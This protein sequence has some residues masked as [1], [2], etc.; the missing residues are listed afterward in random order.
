V[1]RGVLLYG[2]SGAG[3]SSLINAGL[4]P[5]AI[6]RGFTPERLRVQ[7]RQGAEIVVERIAVD[8]A[9]ARYL[10]S[11]LVPEDD[12][13]PRFVLSATAFR[14]RVLEAAKGSS[15]PLL[16]FD[17]FEELVTLFEETRGGETLREGRELQAVVV[18]VLIELL[19]LEELRVKLVLSFREDYLAKVK[20]LLWKRPELVDQ[21]VYLTPP[22]TDA[23]YKIIRGPFESFP[24]R[25]PRE[26]TR[27]LAQRI[28]EAFESRSGPG[29]IHLSE[30]QVVCNRLSETDEPE[31]LF[32]ERGLEGIV[33]DSVLEAIN[34]FPDDLRYSALTVLTQ[35]V[36]GSGVRTVISADDLVERV[37]DD[38][39]IEESQ[40]REALRR[41]EQETRLVR[42]E[43]RRDIDVYEIISE[44]LV[45]WIS[46]LREQRL[47]WLLESEVAQRGRWKED[48]QRAH[49]LTESG[50]EKDLLDAVRITTSLLIQSRYADLDTYT[51]ASGL[52]GWLHDAERPTAVRKAAGHGMAAAATMEEEFEPY[53]GAASVPVREV[54][55]PLAGPS[56][57]RS[58]EW[59]IAIF[60]ALTAFAGLTVLATDAIVAGILDVA[61][62]HVDTP[63]LVLPGSA[64][65]LIWGV[66]YTME[67]IDW[68]NERLNPLSAPFRPYWEGVDP[69][70][71]WSAWPFNLVL[72]W[73]TAYAIAA[74]ASAGGIDPAIGF[75]AALV[76]VSAAAL[77]SYNEA[78]FVF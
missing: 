2:E 52:L 15:P 49:G 64:V 50:E 14:E 19:E 30:L 39:V 26:L 69:I 36:T 5:A 46:W 1:Y 78:M 32:E 11:A 44:F 72:P 21:T 24:D 33:E 7:P 76:P 29:P 25:F 62:W 16:V 9:G 56:R 65:A 73:V 63:E 53:A 45:P 75:Y 68:G 57:W 51:K 3:K 59:V 41:L 61:G 77:W 34:R 20:R 22:D 43:H 8:E 12:T 38:E 10:P 42:R 66:L 37:R 67:A 23:L 74:L 54:D 70:E 13:H 27:D 18:E 40:V 71:S 60:V 17:Q 55:A 35:M 58:P 4:L 48:L 28:A 6:D 47:K 31:R